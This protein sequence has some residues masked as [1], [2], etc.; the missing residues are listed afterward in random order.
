M[1]RTITGNVLCQCDSTNGMN[2]PYK[3]CQAFASVAA[4]C[5]TEG[6]FTKGVTG[7]FWITPAGKR[8]IARRK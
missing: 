5:A 6:W 2:Q 7:G 1:K 4:R 8:E 3:P